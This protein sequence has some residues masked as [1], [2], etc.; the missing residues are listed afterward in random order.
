MEPKKIVRAGLLV[1]LLIVLSS[2][3]PRHVTDVRPSMTKEDVI[4]LWGPTHLITHKTVNGTAVETWEYHFATTDSVCWV[5]F[6]QDKVSSSPQCRSLPP[7]PYYYPYS[8]PPYPYYY[9]GYYRYYRPY[10]PPYYPY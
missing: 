2:C 6:V 10:Y 7:G 4:A 9:G 3:H 1:V 5:S 8:Y